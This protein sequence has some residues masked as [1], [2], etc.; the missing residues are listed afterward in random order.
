MSNQADLRVFPSHA[1]GLLCALP[2]L[3]LA[4]FVAALAS[5][6]GYAFLALI[7]PVLA[8]ALYQY[9]QSGLLVGP[10]VI[11]GLRIE[12]GRLNVCLSSGSQHTVLVAGESRV[13]AR[14][15]IL[16]LQHSGSISKSHSIVLVTFAP[17]LC[18]TS[19]EAFRRLRV[20]LRLGHSSDAKEPGGQVRDTH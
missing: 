16:K 20:W 2:W 4:V 5:E 19:P 17:W 8:G 7:V 6:F 15:A 11:T 13:G 14:F 3:T 1:V 10:N 12:N 9:R 18:N